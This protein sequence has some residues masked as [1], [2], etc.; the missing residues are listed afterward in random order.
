VTTGVEQDIENWGSKT[1][2]R[3]KNFAAAP[4][5]NPFCPPLIGG[6]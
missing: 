3:P 6:K 1:V 5:T 2:G 4:P